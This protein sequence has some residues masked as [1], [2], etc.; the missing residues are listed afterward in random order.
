[1]AIGLPGGLDAIFNLATGSGFG[2]WI[3]MGITLIASTIVG[4]I[5]LILILSTFGKAW[6]ERIPVARAFLVILAI[7]LITQLGIVGLISGFVP[8]GGMALHIVSLLLWIGLI[9]VFFSAMRTSHAAVVG[10]VGY[11]VNLIIVPMLMGYVLGIVPA[12]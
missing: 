11:V 10:I 8:G 1:M 2:T 4:G 6:H 3:N 12:F 9:K 5:V 7:N